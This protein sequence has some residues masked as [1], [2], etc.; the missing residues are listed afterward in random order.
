M[1]GK[2][3][4]GGVYLLVLW[5]LWAQVFSG[6]RGDPAEADAAETAAD[7]ADAQKSVSGEIRDAERDE[8]TRT[9]WARLPE[10]PNWD[11]W[12]DAEG[13]S[14][15]ILGN[16]RSILPAQFIGPGTSIQIVVP[17]PAGSESLHAEFEVSLAPPSMDRDS[18]RLLFRWLREE[19]RA[20]GIEMTGF[21]WSPQPAA[22]EEED[23]DGQNQ[24]E[25]AEDAP[26]TECDIIG[27]MDTFRPGFA[28]RT[29]RESTL[30]GLPMPHVAEPPEDG[31]EAA[32]SD[33]DEPV[34]PDAAWACSTVTLEL[35]LH[36]RQIPPAETEDAS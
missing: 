10:A 20:E 27:L 32:A 17:E 33:A 36:F 28:E 8:L 34:D 26:Y 5:L 6:M 23:E 21:T 2:L 30:A 31:E 12:Q 15:W 14:R 1:R 24:E 11:E 18:S 4:G 3:I 16:I 7:A 19:A 22:S 35:S 25:Q 13:A 29:T 9:A